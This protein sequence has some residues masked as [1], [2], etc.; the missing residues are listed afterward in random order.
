MLGYAVV[1]KLTLVYLFV[2]KFV[3]YCNVPIFDTEMNKAN[4]YSYFFYFFFYYLFTK[5][6]GVVFAKA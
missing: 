5:V 3:A 2:K 6:T 4:T 1:N